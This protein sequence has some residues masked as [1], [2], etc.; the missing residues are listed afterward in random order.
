MSKRFGLLGETLSY[1]QSPKIHQMLYA[2]LESEATYECLEIPLNTF[3]GE[4]TRARLKRFD[5]F[6]VTIPYKEAILSL[7][8]EIDPAAERIG[9]VNTVVNEMG[10]FKGYNTDYDGFLRVVK[11]VGIEKY[12]RA[13]ILGTGGAA[14][15]AVVALEDLG[16]DEIIII[17]RNPAIAQAKFERY[18][19]IDYETFNRQ[20]LSSD[21]LVNCTPVG[22]SVLEA[23]ESIENEVLKKQ[24]FIFDLN[25]SPSITPLLEQGLALGV[26][27]VNGIEMLIA[28]A[29]KAE[30]IWLQ[31]PESMTPKVID[32]ILAVFTK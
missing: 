30:E 29:M 11:K 3:A 32:A 12:G 13:I 8:D 19:C 5:G 10:S 25:Y 22:Q 2:I 15:M 6:N 9:A 17:S 7:L 24:G 27:G 31:V 14:K 16:F 28:Q 21:L 20:G 23:S 18:Y 1:S 26:R 4:L